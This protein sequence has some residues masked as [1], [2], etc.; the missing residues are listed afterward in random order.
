MNSIEM[1]KS[2]LAEQKKTIENKGGNVN[3]ANLNVSPSEITAGIK[4]IVV[5]DYKLATANESDVAE[6]KT[7]FSTSSQLKTGTSIHS[8][9]NE[10]IFYLY[11]GSTVVTEST[12]SI[13]KDWSTPAGLTNLREYLF[14]KS[15]NS[16]TVTFHDDLTLIGDYAFAYAKNFKFPNFNQLKNVEKIG[17]GAFQFCDP[18]QFD[19]S[20]LPE[21]VKHYG[22]NAFTNSIKPGC[23]IRIPSWIE[24][25]G[26]YAFSMN[27][28]I[29]E[30][31][32]VIIDNN[33]A[34]EIPIGTFQF[35]SAPIDFNMHPNAAHFSQCFNYRGSFNNVTVH[36]GI[37][38]FGNL[39]LGAVD[40]DPVSN[41]HLKTVTFESETPPTFGVNSIATQHLTNGVKIYVPDTAVSAYKTKLNF[42]KYRNYIYPVSEKE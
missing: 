3:V 35:I 14:W 22:Q 12:E 20:A 34:I 39:A 30:I 18:N 5:P 36:S 6:G 37:Q 31:E 23:T 27:T 28:N 29:V 10:R 9:E 38:N 19:L 2:E 7:Y 21:C 16:L 32:N 40:T 13:V 17:M 41:F 1:L 26:Q 24:S 8:A 25:L 33:L 4:S 11:D 42:T 15:P